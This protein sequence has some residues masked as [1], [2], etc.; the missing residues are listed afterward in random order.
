M[1]RISNRQVYAQDNTINDN[2]YLLGT[3][4]VTGGT[5]TFSLSSL[6][7]HI[8]DGTVIPDVVPRQYVP[9]V[10]QDGQDI[11]MSAIR[12]VLTALTGEID[13]A[14]IVGEDFRNEI[15]LNQTTN[16]QIRIVF[17][18][19]KDTIYLPSLTDRSFQGTLNN[20]A[21][22]NFT[23]TIGAYQ[24]F[25]IVSTTNTAGTTTFSTEFSFNVTLD[26]SSSQYTQQGEAF[27]MFNRFAVSNL[28]EVRTD[29]LGNVDIEGDLVVGRDI[30]F[31]GDLSTSGNINGNNLT[32]TGDLAVTSD[33]TSDTVTTRDLT[34]TD[35]SIGPIEIVGADSSVVIN[36]VFTVI[37]PGATE[38]LGLP[39]IRFANA[40]GVIEG[41]LNAAEMLDF[42]D[43]A[44]AGRALGIDWDYDADTGGLTGSVI[45]PNLGVADVITVEAEE[46]DSTDA[47]AL[48]YLYNNLHDDANGVDHPWHR[49]DI[50][51]VSYE[52]ELEVDD[53]RDFT[54]SQ[55][56]TETT[57]QRS[58]LRLQ[59]TAEAT[60]LQ[61]LLDD[62]LSG[63]T[64][65][66]VANVTRTLTFGGEQ[67][68]VT[69]DTNFARSVDILDFEADGL[70]NAVTGAVGDLDAPGEGFQYRALFGLPNPILVNGDGTI[71]ITFNSEAQALEFQRLYGVT[72]NPSVSGAASVLRIGSIDYPIPAGTFI[73]HPAASAVVQVHTFGFGS[74]PNNIM[75]FEFREE[76][77]LGAEIVASSNSAIRH[78]AQT[79]TNIFLATTAERD[80]L[81]SLFR[82][83]LTEGGSVSENV[84]LRFGPS[85]TLT[86]AAQAGDRLMVQPDPDIPGIDDI[87]T[88]IAGQTEVVLRET[89]NAANIQ[90]TLVRGTTA[91][92]LAAGTGYTYVAPQVVNVPSETIVS[93]RDTTGP[94]RQSVRFELD[95]NLNANSSATGVGIRASAIGM[96]AR[97]VSLS[98]LYVGAD[99]LLVA[100]NT[101]PADWI[102]ITPVNN[103]API[104]GVTVLSRAGGTV[105]P[106]VAPNTTSEVTV[107]TNRLYVIAD[108]GIVLR[109]P[110]TPSLGDQVIL[111]NVSGSSAN[112][113]VVANAN[114]RVQ[115][116]TDPVELDDPNA[117]FSLYYSGDPNIGWVFVGMQSYTRLGA[118]ELIPDAP[119]A[120]EATL[121]NRQVIEA[122]QTIVIPANRAAGFF[123][124]LQDDPDNGDLITVVNRSGADGAPG[125]PFPMIQSFAGAVNTDNILFE[126]V[127][128]AIVGLPDLVVD[129]ADTFSLVFD[130]NPGI[131]LWRV[132]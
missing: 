122:G 121:A 40:T 5:K 61:A 42:T 62:D 58:R 110:A 94:V 114:Q 7:E 68:T 22:L 32:A 128:G 70:F 102:N 29:I 115:G 51:V 76:F 41:G 60:R 107:S 89:A 46:S 93:S 35:A 4:S 50:A 45:L 52:T 81:F 103:F 54:A 56:T 90:V 11:E 69:E 31:D 44:S 65:T 23:G 106:I 37:P 92:L 95:F 10:T 3:D 2:D 125:N 16:G 84:A 113:I 99:Q 75:T 26:D 67:I 36:G 15:F 28:S 124:S 20:Q 74:V 129:T 55:A 96:A 39:I 79:F 112:Q 132:I 49:G 108:T 66:D 25:N 117:S 126:P 14:A 97:T 88:L 77:V 82:P 33:I 53:I 100:A 6:A 130:G 98:L 72:G 63:A 18:N 80:S 116:S 19:Y 21:A 71:T 87:I 17:R 91:T 47:E 101:V 104:Q 30:L 118:N 13:L 1:A 8:Q 109:L 119:G 123:Y 59:N 86:A 85:L 78:F 64:D 43:R 105:P 127:P 34:S 12:Q 111:S 73:E 131:N 27:P 24:G 57:E 83:T 48:D 9:V 120:G 38:A